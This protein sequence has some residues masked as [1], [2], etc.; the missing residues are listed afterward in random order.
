MQPGNIKITNDE[1]GL[2]A[3]WERP[4]AYMNYAFMGRHIELVRY[5][6]LHSFHP[7]QPYRLVV[8]KDWFWWWAYAAW[9]WVA[10]KAGRINQRALYFAA[11]HRIIKAQEGYELK[12]HVANFRRR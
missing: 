9:D 5:H 12:W 6:V 4:V 3:E 11:R 8:N 2:R 7:N 1:N 10:W